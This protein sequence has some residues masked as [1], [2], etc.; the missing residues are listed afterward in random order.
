M[1]S[2]KVVGSFVA[3]AT[4]A[5]ALFSGPIASAQTPLS[6]YQH[7]HNAVS[8]LCLG[9][10]GIDAHA[11]GTEVEVYHCNPG[12]GD[13][14]LDNQWTFVLLSNGY[15]HILNR[16]SS[17][18]LGVRGVD[19]HT[20]GTGVEVYHCNPGGGDRGLDN[21]WRIVAEPDGFVVIQNRVSGLCLGVVGVDAHGPGAGAEVYHCN[22]GGADPG[23]DNRWRF[24]RVGSGPAPAAAPVPAPVP[25]PAPTAGDFFAIAGAFPARGAA[26]A[27]AN[28]LGPGW[29]VL[30]SNQ[31]S[32]FTPGFW[33]AA[34]GP[35]DQTKAERFARD[36]REGANI[37][38]AYVKT[39][40]N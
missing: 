22:P 5:F 21:Q 17:L 38:D 11:P 40:D 10:R 27:R 25:V 8:D 32:N 37:R 12:G 16:V 9:V 24:Q 18:C 30:S 31:C 6:G 7:I 4:S 33:I 19:N 29:H 36:A 35:F 1:L 28:Q 39:C 3:L 20:P 13:R 23:R 15:V 34:A 26:Q 2:T 14:G